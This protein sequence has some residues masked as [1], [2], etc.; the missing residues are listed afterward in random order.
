[1]QMQ[2]SFDFFTLLFLAL[3]VFV[4]WKLRSI[5]G[6]KTGHEKP[7]GDIFCRQ[8]QAKDASRPP[9]PGQPPPREGNVIRL[10]NAPAEPG[11][12]P[13]YPWTGV[14]EPGSPVAA[15]LD[16]IAREEPGFDA[17][18]FLQGASAAYEMIVAAYARGDRKALKG[19]LS[20]E[21]YD[22]FDQDIAAREK[23]KQTAET[24]FVSMDKAEI[25]AAEARGRSAQVTVRLRPKL[26]TVVRDAAGAE[27]SGSATAVV[28]ADE[29]WVFA[30][31]LGS[32][33]PNW[34]LIATDNDG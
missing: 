30:R 11:A 33:D 12:P 24:T 1:M 23:A 9:G 34:L 15:G 28:D 5:L 14:A 16:A 19:L 26:I 32:R 18:V 8:N 7:P 21:V 6:T 20:K 27:V 13:P 2:G 3:A 29:T 31:Q 25:I 10:P 4:A 22:D 17:R